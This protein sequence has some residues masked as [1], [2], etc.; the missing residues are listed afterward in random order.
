MPARK[1]DRMALSILPTPHTP[2]CNKGILRD[3]AE[4]GNQK[5]KETGGE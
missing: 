4:R 2:S 5:E 3:G 1:L